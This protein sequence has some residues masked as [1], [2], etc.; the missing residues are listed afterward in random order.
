MW[1]R[2]RSNRPGK[3]R[4]CCAAFFTGSR[5]IL[6]LLA[7]ESRLGWRGPGGQPCLFC[8]PLQDCSELRKVWIGLRVQGQGGACSLMENLYLRT[9]WFWG[10]EGET[11]IISCMQCWSRVQRAGARAERTKR[12]ALSF[13]WPCTLGSRSRGPGLPPAFSPNVRTWL[14]FCLYCSF[15]EAVG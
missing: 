2:F 6:L 1:H 12:C 13:Q 9:I 8:R 5:V 11:A 7:Q 10:L 3:K 14:R 15:Y 4:R